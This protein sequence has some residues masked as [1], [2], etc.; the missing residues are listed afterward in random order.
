MEIE[1]SEEPI[2][3][4]ADYASVPIAFEV[5]S[6]LNVAVDD[7]DPRAVVLS[8]RVLAAPYVNDYDSIPGEGPN[9]WARNFD[10]SNWG[11]IAARSNGRRVGGAVVAFKTEGV[12]MLEGRDDLAV[13]WDIRVAR[14]ARGEGVGSALFRAVETWAIARGCR[15]L[16]IE[17]QNVNVPACRFY[18]RQ[19]CAIRDIRRDVYPD[20]PDEIQLLW[21][22]DLIGG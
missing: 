21:Y 19:G 14:E 20:R 12:D 9:Q 7:D 5:L 22:K 11:L 2:T 10:L 4:L 15:Q 1:I 6:V 16:K 8:E 13:L 17:T 18:L 3:S